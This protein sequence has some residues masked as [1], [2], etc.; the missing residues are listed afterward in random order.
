[1]AQSP[2][3]LINLTADIT[4]D[5][6]SSFSGGPVILDI[7]D[8]NSDQDNWKIILPDA[9]LVQAGQNFLLNNVSGFSVDITAND[10]S[11]IL[12]SLLSGEVVELYLISNGTANGTWRIIP[13]GG[14]ASSITQFTAESSD[15]SIVITN[16]TVTPPTGIID[17]Q[18]TDSLFNFN[19]LNAT[20]FIVSTNTNPL[21][22][23]TV[24]LIGG[25]NIIVSNGDG[26]LGNPIIDLNAVLTSLTSITVGDMT[27]SGE[28]ITN[29]TANGNIQ[30]NTNG[31]GKIQL[32]GVEIDANG[33]ITGATNLTGINAYA[34]FTDTVTGNTNTIVVEDQVN[35]A[36]ITGSAGTYE[37]TFTTPMATINYGVFISLGS[38]G[39]DLPFISNSYVI[40]RETTSAT[41]IVTDASGELVLSVPNGASVMIISS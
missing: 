27:L 28:V 9:T 41:I 11:T 32:N 16:G 30:I 7:N 36:S 3:Q 33:N 37:L 2:Y 18:L 12:V 19:D 1:M 10:T 8:I 26:I 29:N 17:F 15:A 5:W 25:E 4:L 22:F 38:T 34:F 13:F 35:I 31:T 40:V 39:G 14:G 23:A 20:N 24:E 21:T 6:P